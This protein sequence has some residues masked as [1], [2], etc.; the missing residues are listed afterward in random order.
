[1]NEFQKVLKFICSK[2]G[3]HERVAWNYADVYN[4]IASVEC[5]PC[6]NSATVDVG[7]LS[8]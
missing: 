5:M 2:C 6:G 8:D 4:K 3:E 1:M 7:N